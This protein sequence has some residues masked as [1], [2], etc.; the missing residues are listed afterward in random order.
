MT[1]QLMSSCSDISHSSSAGFTGDNLDRPDPDAVIE[2]DLPEEPEVEM[3][4]I[5]EGDNHA[6]AQTNAY[7]TQP[8]AAERAFDLFD[9]G[10]LSE[11]GLLA[12]VGVSREGYVPSETITHRALDAVEQGRLSEDGLVRLLG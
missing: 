8:S 12:A 3:G 7:D 2:P 6:E 4:L 5:A 11:A 10:K 1:C 9:A